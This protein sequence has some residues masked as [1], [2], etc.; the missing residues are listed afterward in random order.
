MTHAITT[1]DTWIDP[2]DR[3]R[4][5]E[6]VAFIRSHDTATV[7]ADMLPD[8]TAEER[9][10][11]GR[12]GR[13]VHAALL[14]FAG[15]GDDVRQV[16]GAC[17]LTVGA[18]AP[19]VVVRDRLCRRY[20]RP[21]RSLEVNIVRAPVGGDDGRRREVEIFVLA[22]APGAG[23][24]EIAESERVHAHET[25]IAL[26]IDEPDAVI[27]SGL[28][29]LLT[30][31]GRMAPDGGGYNAY[32]DATVL[33]F[34][35][36]TRANPLHR[37]LVLVVNGRHPWVLQAHGVQSPPAQG[38]RLRRSAPEFSPAKQLL[39]LMTGAWTTQAIAAAAELGIADHLAGEGATTGSRLAALTG[40]DQGSLSRLL[41]FLASLGIVRR[42]QGKFHLAELGQPLRADVEHSLRP[43][44]LLYGG[45]FYQSFG[46]LAHCV[47]TGQDAFEL[48]F[49]QHNFDYIAERPELA[50][51]FDRAM[52]SSASMFDPI[53]DLVDLSDARVVVDVAGG[54]GELL[55]RLLHAAP[56][57]RGVLLERPHAIEA[58]RGVLAR[59]GCADRAELILGD[60]TCGIPHGGD[61]YILS[62][63]LHDWDDQQCRALLKRCAEAMPAQAELLI[64]ERLLPED[65]S[66][67]LAVAWDIHMMCN[68]GGRERT[69]SQYRDL[70]AE[71]GLELIGQH[72]LPLEAALLRARH[73]GRRAGL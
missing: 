66:P 62:R 55:R 3:D 18:I 2:A 59:A 25:H 53:P 22:V 34:R 45:M 24:E 64:V 58:A 42:T 17:G 60:F 73:S 23:L 13:F 4:I 36:A 47:R 43:L 71:S 49:G 61:V 9:E 37:R 54:N 52:A 65:E 20:A 12:H 35:D 6:V 30:G 8:L 33:Y 51:L 56:H 11:I 7:L 28:R 32:E 50:D 31:P 38:V 27:L 39:Q 19:S 40:T 5:A 29:E 63:V 72:P 57:L 16:A 46:H 14:V 1:H 10:V 15:E 68:V 41:R 70:L 21:H 44:A 48:L 67:S 69:V 26:Q